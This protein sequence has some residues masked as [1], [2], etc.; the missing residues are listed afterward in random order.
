MKHSNNT[1]SKTPACRVAIIF[2]EDGQ[3]YFTVTDTATEEQLLYSKAFEHEDHCA[4]AARNLIESES[5]DRR[6][7]IKQTQKGQFYFVLK[8]N[9]NKE[10][11]RSPLLDSSDLVK[12]RMGI[13]K[14][15]GLDTE[16]V[17][18]G[19]EQEAQNAPVE[20]TK[21]PPTPP[22]KTKLEIHTADANGDD[23]GQMLRYKFT[24][25]FYPN[26]GL[27]TLKNDFSS[28]TEQL[29]DCDGTLIERF[30]R[31]QLP[32]QKETEVAPQ[33][34]QP[35]SQDNP[36]IPQPTLAAELP[37]KA[38]PQKSPE[39]LDLIVVDK[40]GNP[41]GSNYLL[42]PNEFFSIYVESPNGILDG[43]FDVQ[44]TIKSIADASNS[45]SGTIYYLVAERGRLF[46]PVSNTPVM[47]PGTYMVTAQLS[48]SKQFPV[49]LDYY[50]SRLIVLH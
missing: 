20:P 5:N 3:Y 29:K 36:P 14:K 44:L 37:E 33:Q 7:E 15:M 12:K 42:M 9:G 41:L 43:V 32:L 27:W 24:I 11:G 39:I 34:N 8:L 18:P 38:V 23:S 16:V 28:E 13:L 48:R 1:V 4:R 50:G 46:I 45:V 31:A 6:F 47:Q 40:L 30:L 35:I 49:V 2:R 10:T 26:S 21:L 25:I 17:H 22:Q 19:N